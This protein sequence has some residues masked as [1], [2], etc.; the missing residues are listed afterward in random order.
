MTYI[1]FISKIIAD[2][3]QFGIQDNEFFE[4]HHILPLCL[5]GQGDYKNGKF[6]YQISKHPNCIRL[7]PR[8]H[9]IA[10]KLL[11]IE[12]PNNPKLVWAWQA[13][14]M[15]N[16]CCE[17]YEP[18]PE[19]YEERKLLLHQ[20]GLSEETRFRMSI[21]NAGSKN[22]MYGKHHSEETREKLRQ[23]NLGKKMHWWTNGIISTMAEECPGDGWISGRVK[24]FHDKKPRK[25]YIHPKQKQYLW[26]LP[27]GTTKVM[28]KTNVV[29]WHKD[30][31]LVKE[32]IEDD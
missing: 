8:E 11:A 23:A 24:G 5:G 4:Q 18:T 31:K 7:Y 2:R 30:W 17:R 1:E 12:N 16:N 19:E 9:F 22:G 27:D 6:K 15:S 28:D 29:R 3:G 20:C 25:A 14:W 26:K 21:A 10:H 32:I 13:M